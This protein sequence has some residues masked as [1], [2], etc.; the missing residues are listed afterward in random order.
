VHVLPLG[1]I[2]PQGGDRD[3]LT[4]D[5]DGEDLEDVECQGQPQQGG[6]DQAHH[7]HH[8]LRD[9]RRQAGED[10]TGDVGVDGAALADGLDQGGE[11]VVQ[12]HHLRGILGDVGPGAPHGH[13][14]VG[15]A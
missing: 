4:Q 8:E 1:A 12:E 3:D 9:V 11:G 5:V 13:P 6:E 2:R 10:P 7:V 14:D 15:V